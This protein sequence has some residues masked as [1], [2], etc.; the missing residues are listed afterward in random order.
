LSFFSSDRPAAVKGFTLVELM[1]AMTILALLAA[2]AVPAFTRDVQQSAY[3][4]FGVELLQAVQQAKMG[5]ASARDDRRLNF[6]I[7][8]NQY[9]LEST[10]AGTPALLRSVAGG[11][12]EVSKLCPEARDTG[13]C[14]DAEVS[15]SAAGFMVVFSATRDVSLIYGGSP[16]AKSATIYYR[17]RDDH[18]RG[19]VV[20]YQATA[21][22]RQYDGW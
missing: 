8:G 3:R 2:V 12:V 9:L 10:A 1:A 17:T 14:T 13:T 11:D 18:Y 5:A 7:G 6:L 22:A 4:R 19:R 20:I 21:Y 15:T 16:H